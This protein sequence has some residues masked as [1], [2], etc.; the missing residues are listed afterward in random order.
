M[1]AAGRSADAPASP[2]SPTEPTSA[3]GER[4]APAPSPTS[5]F[6]AV[7]VPAAAAM[8]RASFSTRLAL[9]PSAKFYRTSSC[10]ASVIKDTFT[11]GAL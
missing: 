5:T 6:P 7:L 3:S 2:R 9:D 1:S 8:R 10:G 4:S 11:N